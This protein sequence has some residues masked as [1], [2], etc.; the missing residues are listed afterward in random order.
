M[1]HH[2]QSQGRH[3]LPMWMVFFVLAGCSAVGPSMA[4]QFDCS[5]D[6]AIPEY[7]STTVPAYVNY[8]FWYLPVEA[9]AGVTQRDTVG[10]HSLDLRNRNITS[11]APGGLDC[12][13]EEFPGGDDDDIYDGLQ[14]QAILLD[15]N[16]LEALPLMVLFNN[17]AAISV[18]HNRISSL[19][20]SAFAGFS[21]EWM[22]VDISH[23][24]I[25][26]MG[27]GTF[28]NFDGRGL[29]LNMGQNRME[30]LSDCLFTGFSAQALSVD[31][32][33]NRLRS[34]G[35]IFDGFTA[36]G[37]VRLGVASNELTADAVRSAMNSYSSSVAV[38][39]LDFSFNHVTELPGGVFSNLL[40]DTPGHGDI[41]LNLSWNPLQSISPT[42]FVGSHSYIRSILLD[43]SHPTAG[44]LMAPLQPFNFSGIRWHGPPGSGLGVRIYVVLTNTN[45]DL[46]IV[47]A[48]SHDPRGPNGVLLDLSYN[49]YTVVP[50]GV[51]NSS[52]VTL[53]NLSNCRI[54]HLSDDAFNYTLRLQ[55][56]D[57][58]N[59]FLTVEK[60]AFVAN[61]PGLDMLVLNNNHI[62][63]V[64]L[65]SN[66]IANSASGTGNV[67][68]CS[69]YGPTASGCV[70]G[71]GYTLASGW[72]GYVRCIPSSTPNGCGAGAIFNSTDCSRAPFSA[73]VMGTVTGQFYSESDTAFLTISRCTSAF[74]RDGSYLNA[75]EVDPPLLNARGT[76]TSDRLCSVC[77]V[78]PAG[79]SS[80]PCTPTTD[81]KCFRQVRLTVGD[82]A[83][84]ALS[85]VILAIVTAAGIQYGR[86]QSRRRAVALN[87]LALT[88]QLLGDVQVEKDRFA[89]ENDLMEQAWKIRVFDL[90]FG[91]VI[92]EGSYGRVFKGSWGHIPVAIKVLRQ[93]IDDEV[94]QVLEDF[95]REVKFMRSIRHPHILTFYGAGVDRE[96][97]AFLVTE[98][99]AATLKSLLAEHSKHLSW[100][101]RIAFAS[102]VASG[103][104]YL[105]E[106]ETIHRDLKAENCFVDDSARVKVADFGT[107]RIASV[108]SGQTSLFEPLAMASGPSSG[109]LGGMRTER[110]LSRGVGSL[111]WMAPEA[112]TGSVTESQAAALD[113]YS[114][115]IVM[116]E[117]WTRETPWDEVDVNGIELTHR[118]S[119]LVAS[120][121]R[122]RTP[123][124]LEIAPTGFQ[125]LMERCWAS[126]ASDR[127]AFS[128]IVV[129][130]AVIEGH[131]LCE[132]VM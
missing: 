129:E 71:P 31:L 13:F 72:C 7:C 98:L 64:P 41:T 74:P 1:F 123:K 10:L 39:T 76:A 69:L 101:L 66:H 24:L 79:F 18:R 34:I 32:Y 102:D 5:L 38:L 65:T 59:N 29:I 52:R 113:V 126:N 67:L 58:S 62:L 43:L 86:K 124:G 73:C 26:S 28:S 17:T 51:F 111:M 40:A 110:T 119:E 118:V 3:P 103:M 117:I 21:G 20:D 60:A 104:K 48:L 46:S 114:Y 68:Q 63:A 15:Y 85:V 4:C 11:I 30:E 70:C 95:H 75:Y 80:N 37:Y 82:V 100:R 127:P 35:S 2:E 50:A 42:A 6:R 107:G 96:S 125:A 36:S 112:L 45:V 9:T 12:F 90:H 47:R 33:G 16:E 81:T 93:P 131:P 122:P 55:I 53:L 61:T 14:T 22:V 91:D 99:M 130:L 105:H 121:A 23:N 89:H 88:E 108:A 27:N 109:A 94:P 8:S 54:T 77:S 128:V 92:G 115:A 132:T 44:P 25:T 83:A 84:V 78:C 120:G 56:L 49:N 19:G 97:R 57:L 106:M 116:W 87:E